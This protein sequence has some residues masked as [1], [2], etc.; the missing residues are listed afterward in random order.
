[1]IDYRR[2]MLFLHPARNAADPAAVDLFK[3]SRL[4]LSVLP[5]PM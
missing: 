2:N 4:D 3:P 1:M 5:P